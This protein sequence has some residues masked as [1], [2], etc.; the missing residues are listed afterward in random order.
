MLW[1]ARRPYDP[2]IRG[3]LSGVFLIGY[4]LA[5]IAAEFFREPDV[6]IGY[7]AGGITMGQL[8]SLPMRL[9]H[10]PGHA[11][12]AR[13]ERWGERARGPPAPADPRPRPHVA[14]PATW[15]LAHL[16]GY[17]PRRDPLGRAGD[18]VTAPEVS[19]LFGELIGWPWSSIGWISA[20]PAAAPSWN[21][22]RDAAR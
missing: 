10:L 2:Q 20:G 12:A 6:Q 21:S 17:Y 4:A 1:F 5:R 15:R 13:V 16:Q 18:F 11:R 22:A 14:A 7:L 19:Q 8:L 3:R 9:R